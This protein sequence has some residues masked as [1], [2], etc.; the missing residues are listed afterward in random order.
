MQAGHAI[1]PSRLKVLEDLKKRA[2]ARLLSVVASIQKLE[3][4]ETDDPHEREE[5]NQA[6][7]AAEGEL[8]AA[9]DALVE[10]N[11]LYANCQ[12]AMEADYG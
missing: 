11:T 1:D 12:K 5:I 3:A 9:R 7:T 8:E 2:H 10:A 4:K 6:L